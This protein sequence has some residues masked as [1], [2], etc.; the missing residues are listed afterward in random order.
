MTGPT[1]ALYVRLP[2]DLH[3]RLMEAVNARE[4]WKRKGAIQSIVIDSLDKALAPTSAPKAKKG[5][6]K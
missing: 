2:A 1:V 4:P 3:A 6:S 5:R